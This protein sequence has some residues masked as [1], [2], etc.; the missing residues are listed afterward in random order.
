MVILAGRHLD[1][2]EG[3]MRSG[4][5]VTDEDESALRT[6]LRFVAAAQRSG[7]DG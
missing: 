7:E 1:P 2:E 6:V 4:H 3:V 5:L